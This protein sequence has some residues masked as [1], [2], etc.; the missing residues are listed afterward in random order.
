VLDQSIGRHLWCRDACGF[1]PN[2]FAIGRQVVSPRRLAIPQRILGEAIVRILLYFCQPRPANSFP[3]RLAGRRL[4][5]AAP[6]VTNVSRFA[7]MITDLTAL[8][9]G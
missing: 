9:F 5:S 4:D 7:I 3:L 8:R 1:F 2:R 6:E